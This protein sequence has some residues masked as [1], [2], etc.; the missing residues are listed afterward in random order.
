MNHF[1]RKCKEEEDQPFTLTFWYSNYA[2]F[3]TFEVVSEFL[4][5]LF[6]T[7]FLFGFDL[8]KFQLTDLQATGSFSKL[9]G[10]DEHI[11][12]MLHLCYCAFNL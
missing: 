9:L 4:N 3:F 12:G 10:F 2:Y 6:F 1:S 5:V 7:L 11:E 8:G